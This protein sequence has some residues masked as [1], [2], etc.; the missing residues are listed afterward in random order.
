MVDGDSLLWHGFIICAAFGVLHL[1]FK[2]SLILEGIES[3]LRYSVDDS[4]KGIREELRKL[5]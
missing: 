1:L 4:L 3:A 2:I 5:H